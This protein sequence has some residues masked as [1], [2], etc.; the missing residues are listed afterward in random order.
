VK[1]MRAVGQIASS[2]FSVDTIHLIQSQLTPT[3][4]IY[5]QLRT[6]RADDSEK[7]IL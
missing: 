1:A 7:D 5:T 6:I 3:G 4:A 2:P